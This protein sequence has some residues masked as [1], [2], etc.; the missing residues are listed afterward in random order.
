MIINT[1]LTIIT[2]EASEP[3]LH[4]LGHLKRDLSESMGT[5]QID[6][7]RT[8][9]QSETSPVTQ[10]GSQREPSPLTPGEKKK[11][12]LFRVDPLQCGRWDLNP[13]DV[14]I[15]RSL[16]LLVC[17]FRHFRIPSQIAC[18]DF[19]KIPNFSINVN[20]FFKSQ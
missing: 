12:Q 7:L 14:S 13:H 3:V 18:C 10:K 2:G 20:T 16:V 5:F 11:D 8:M 17:Q 19:Y 9:S 15:T 4:A 6:S 1:N